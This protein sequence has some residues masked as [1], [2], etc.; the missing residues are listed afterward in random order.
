MARE[1][2]IKNSKDKA[3]YI[4]RL[5]LDKKAEDVII[6]DMKKVSAYCDFFVIAG[7]QSSRKVK[8]IG[9]GVIEG[10]QKKGMRVYHV[11]GEKDAMWML[12]DCDDI[13]VHIFHNET[14]SFYNLERLWHDA[15][16]E[17]VT[18]PCQ[19]S[20]SKQKLPA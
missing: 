6:M 11:E 17:Y 1:E 15:P 12:L 8:A 20:I 14:R 7:G 9:D 3:L 19:E 2:Y 5:V 4:S 18:D 16:K 13:V 10:L